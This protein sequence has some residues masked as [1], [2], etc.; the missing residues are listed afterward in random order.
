MKIFM[1]IT[2][3]TETLQLFN[4]IIFMKANMIEYLL[5]STNCLYNDIKYQKGEFQKM[6]TA[7]R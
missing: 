6:E 4:S 5:I 2:R 7:I 3:S 1:D